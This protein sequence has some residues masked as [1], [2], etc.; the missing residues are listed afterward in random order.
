MNTYGINKEE[1]DI[2]YKEILESVPTSPALLALAAIIKAMEPIESE[3]KE[4]TCWHCGGDISIAN[5]KGCCSHIHYPESCDV[6]SGRLDTE[7]KEEHKQTECDID[8]SD[9]SAIWPETKE[10]QCTKCNGTKLQ[11]TTS[12]MINCYNCKE[13]GKE[14]RKGELKIEEVKQYADDLEGLLA[15]KEAKLSRYKGI[16]EKID[17]LEM[18]SG[19][20][21][22]RDVKKMVRT[23]LAEEKCKCAEMSCKEDCTREHT[24]KEFSCDIC[25]PTEAQWQK[26]PETTPI[27]ETQV[28]NTPKG[29]ESYPLQEIRAMLEGLKIGYVQ[30]ESNNIC[31][32]H[33]VGCVTCVRKTNQQWKDEIDALIKSL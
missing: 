5:P 9:P 16:L 8:Y 12:G 20:K 6:C 19:E 30:R 26:E 18:A 28:T 11:Y 1:L 27:P 23:A 32:A 7:K 4:E 10:E 31:L 21:T 22:W 13:T 2:C 15:L 29:V 14:P 25:R 33:G 24:H 17:E 3:K